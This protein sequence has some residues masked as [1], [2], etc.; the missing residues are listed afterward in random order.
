MKMMTKPGEQFPMRRKAWI[1]LKQL[2]EQ[3]G[4][5]IPFPT[6][7]VQGSGDSAEAA[8]ARLHMAAT[9]SLAVSQAQQS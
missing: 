6:V 3:N 1:R 4:I 8:A 2:F 7:R 5:E 9:E